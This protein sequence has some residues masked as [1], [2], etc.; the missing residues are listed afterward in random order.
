MYPLA[1]IQY[2]A[3]YPRWASNP[4]TCH[5]SYLD[6]VLL[7]VVPRADHFLRIVIFQVQYLIHHMNV[8]V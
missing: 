3:L 5:A 1:P 7:F 2:T 4:C 8:L 6:G